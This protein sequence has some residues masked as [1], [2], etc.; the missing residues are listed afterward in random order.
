MKLLIVTNLYPLPWEPNRAT[1]NK[2]QFDRLAERHELTL[3]VPIA[4]PEYLR[5]RAQISS[6]SA[7]TKYTVKYICYWYTPKLFQQHFGHFMFWSVLK[8]ARELISFSDFDAVLGSWAHPDGFVAQK[9]SYRLKLPYFIK[10]HGSDIN[11][12]TEDKNR[13]KQI[14]QVCKG[15]THIFTP[16]D[17]LR[18]KVCGLGVEK[19]K[20]TRVYNGV[21]NKLFYPEEI[22]SN[23]YF[24]F[25]GNLKKDKGVLDLLDAYDG[26]VKSGGSKLLKFIGDGAMSPVLAERVAAYGLEAK[27][28]MLGALKHADTAKYIRQSGLLILPSYHEGVPNV[29]LEAANCGV[30]VVSTRVGGIPEVVKDG[31]SGILIEAGDCEALTKAMV[32]FDLNTACWNREVIKAHGNLFSWPK[33]V[34]EIDQ[35]ICKAVQGSSDA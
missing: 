34:N 5:K 23:P 35:I 30:P 10:V 1:F 15:A 13:N 9:L 31:V 2:Q 14:Q 21:D 11:V 33:N 17:A 19:S 28:S 24:L 8:G 6:Y 3:I 22:A 16:S 12:L 4:W 29:L 7:S 20:V 25:V 27:V 32:D 26:Y 18:L